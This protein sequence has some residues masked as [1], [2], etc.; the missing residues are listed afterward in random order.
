MKRYFISS[1][2]THRDFEP[3]PTDPT[4][5]TNN[6]ERFQK[7]VYL[8]AK[9]IAEKNNWKKIM[10][11]GTGAGYKLIK[12]FNDYDT[13]GT[14]VTDTVNWLKEKYADKKWSDSMAPQTGYDIIICADVIEHIVDP[15]SL[16]DMIEQSNAKQIIISTVDRNLGGN[17][18]GPP[19]NPHHCREWTFE[20]FFLYISSRFE[21][22]EHLIINKRQKT[23][24]IVCKNK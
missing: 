22:I 15:D 7:E 1:N 14:D 20:E 17:Q 4:K 18:Y 19:D 6:S 3:K 8:K 16:L 24:M 2:Y 23:Q 13:L 5:P 10:D 9:D 21:I 11:I 12:Y